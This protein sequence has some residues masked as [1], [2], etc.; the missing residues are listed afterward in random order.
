MCDLIWISNQ[1]D[2][3][4]TVKENVNTAWLFGDVNI[5]RQNNG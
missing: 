5:Y 1:T 4:E 3:F 2:H